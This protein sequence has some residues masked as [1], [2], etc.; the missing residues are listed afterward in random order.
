MRM[1]LSLS[2]ETQVLGDKLEVNKRTTEDREN[3]IKRE[4]GEPVD[5]AFLE[6]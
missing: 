3:D 6:C 5:V 2:C 4:F 1:K